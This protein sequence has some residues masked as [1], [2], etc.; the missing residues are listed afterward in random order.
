M[1]DRLFRPRLPVANPPVE[2]PPATGARPPGD[3]APQA[4]P[5][6]AA[7]VADAADAANAANPPAPDAALTPA[8]R[9][10]VAREQLRMV[11]LHTRVGTLAASAFALLLAIYLMDHPDASFG[12]G[13][14]Q[15]WLGIKLAVAAAR[16]GLA[17]AYARLGTGGARWSGAAYWQR[18][19]GAMLGL[20]V[21]DGAV[22]GLGGGYLVGESVP[23]AALGVAVLDGI[24]CVATFGLQV[25]LAAT[26]A[27]VLPILLPTALGLLWREDE[28]AYFASAGQL[29]LAA[30]MLFT[31]RATSRQLSSAMQLSLQSAQLVREKDAALQL[32]REQSAERTRFL[33][34]VSHE[35]RTPLH[36]MLGLT[37]LLHLESRD[38]THTLRLELVESSG[39]H[40]LELINDLL[41]VSRISAGQFSLSSK[42]FDLN[43]LLVQVAE[44]FKLRAAD[45]GLAFSLQ[46]TLPRPHWV[47]GDASR[48]RQVLNN[49]LGN[50]VK[51]TREGAISLEASAGPGARTVQLAVQD[52]GDGIGPAEQ[53]R[54]F[55]PFHQAG[56]DRP[57]DG[58]G[59]G[60]TIAREIA[61][62][63]GGDIAV[64]STPGL[65]SRFS[66]TAC[67][68][69][70]SRPGAGVAGA[71]GGAGGP[72]GAATATGSASAETSRLPRLVL[73]AED[74]DVNALI[75]RAFLDGLGV[76]SE[77]V[78]DGKQ[79]VSRALRETERPELVLMDCRMPVMDGL[80]AAAEIRRQER[81]LGLPR[82]PIL[83]LTATV[84][85]E[86]RQACMAAGMDRVI[87][88]PFTQPQLAQAMR[89]AV[90]PPARD[91]PG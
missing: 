60:L 45:K 42:P 28:I 68:P 37:R 90:S 31:A 10:Q 50:A 66:F 14:V 62:A 89:S 71:A 77:R 24:A 49:L 69:D 54:I 9:H 43:A 32:A 20:L 61:I 67:L 18:W 1:I 87:G 12:R 36:G 34:K 63:M 81:T 47:I 55:Q 2:D 29:I 74:D 79:A 4:A 41:D 57:T 35:L 48:V 39:I 23:L 78:T 86:D 75:V 19:Q 3:G 16:I 70:A 22:W 8:H 73:V 58:V 72:A 40:L 25:R 82:L 91:G 53:A 85:D 59:L 13:A 44:V 15:A 6:D 7:D 76:R 80:S 51:F 83:A 5:T 65:G 30:L 52:S 27:Y 26:A 88:K 21:I 84:N 38:P 33:A 64:H 17:Q 46:S 11:L 56:V